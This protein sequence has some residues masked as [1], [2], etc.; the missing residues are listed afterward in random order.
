M[1]LAAEKVSDD[2]ILNCYLS[3]KN[4]LNV[5]LRHF[6]LSPTFEGSKSAYNWTVFAP[7]DVTID[8]EKLAHTLDAEMQTLNLDYRDCREVGVLGMAQ[9]TVISADSLQKYFEDNRTKGQFKM[10]TTFETADE[11]VKFMAANI[12]KQVGVMQ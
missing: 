7:S 8:T 2:N 9:V 1:N 12:D 4:A 3:A 6:F 10:K 5:D 11:Y